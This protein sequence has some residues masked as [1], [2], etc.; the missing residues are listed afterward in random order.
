MKHGLQRAPRRATS[1]GEALPPNQPMAMLRRDSHMVWMVLAGG[2]LFKLRCVRGT[3]KEKRC[4]EKSKE[5]NE[6]EP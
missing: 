4:G 2:I 5:P 3:E 1:A 6:E